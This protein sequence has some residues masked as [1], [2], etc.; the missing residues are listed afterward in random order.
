[1]EVRILNLCELCK[2]NQANIHLTQDD[3]T[4]QEICRDCFNEIAAEKMGIDLTPFESGV[5]EYPGKNGKMHRFMINKMVLPVGIGYE[6][7][8][9]F[10]SSLASGDGSCLRVGS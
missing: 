9:L 1:M 6:A 8:E 7:F 3:G 5:Y 4:T 10:G 2:K